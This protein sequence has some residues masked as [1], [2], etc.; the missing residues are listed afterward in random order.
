MVF[1]LNPR[2][3]SLSN[4]MHNP[5]RAMKTSL[6]FWH[7]KKNPNSPK[8]PKPFFRNLKSFATGLK[9]KKTGLKPV[10]SIFPSI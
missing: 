10:F 2:A 7:A 3:K 4:K 5:S 9:E 8:V 6:F 1:S